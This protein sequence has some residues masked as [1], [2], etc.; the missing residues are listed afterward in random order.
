MLYQ[1]NSVHSFSHVWLFATPW[2]TARQASLSIT[3]S[4]SSH[5]LTSIKSVMPS[6]HLL[7]CRP[8]LFLP[9]VPPSIRVFSNESTLHMKWPKYGVSALA[10][11]L[12]KNTQDWSP[13]EWYLPTY[14]F[15]FLTYSSAIFCSPHLGCPLKTGIF[16]FE[17]TATPVISYVTA[18]NLIPRSLHS[19][20]APSLHLAFLTHIGSLLTSSG[21]PRSHLS[22]SYFLTQWTVH[23]SLLPATPAHFICAF[24]ADLRYSTW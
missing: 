9:P 15:I 4:R 19:I 10:S 22:Y 7:L 2:I 8:L 3:N 24:F 17:E 1:F 6:S 12:P 23:G 11:F 16:R 5:K 20:A 13:L 18:S 21:S 14:S